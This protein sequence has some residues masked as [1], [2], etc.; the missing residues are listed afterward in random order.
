MTIQA[1][2]AAGIS[3]DDPFF[4]KAAVYVSR[5]QNLKG[6]HN[7]QPW[8]KLLDDGS[9]GYAAGPAAERMYNS[10][11]PDAVKPTDPHPGYGSMTCAG[12]LCL[13]LCGV[14]RDDP[15]VVRARKWL[16]DEFTTD[17]NPGFEGP[18]G[19]CGGWGHY[20]YLAHLTK[21]LDRLGVETV[22]DRKG[23]TRDWRAELTRALA[24]RQWKDGSW[25]NESDAFL[26]G[27]PDAAT[28]WALIALS[29]CKPKSK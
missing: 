18:L 16:A 7:D 17:C 28:S 3:R 5:C 23:R 29:H 1:V 25:Q 12:L 20:Y 19:G 10:F 24:E 26:E 21:C 4:R 8:A 14:G 13:D 9:F 27:V 22:T 2:A 11:R 15:R 6:E